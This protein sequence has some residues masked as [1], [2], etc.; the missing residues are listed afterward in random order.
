MNKKSI[1]L[2]LLV[3]KTKQIAVNKPLKITYNDM[4]K[5]SFDFFLELMF[6]MH[7]NK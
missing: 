1:L 7:V 5:D 3:S 2:C 6:L 4:Y